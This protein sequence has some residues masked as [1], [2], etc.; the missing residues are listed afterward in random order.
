MSVMT[1]IYIF[2]GLLIP[3]M[4]NDILHNIH[5]CHQYIKNYSN[6]INRVM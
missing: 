2:M 6:D 5:H 1:V 3:K 4:P